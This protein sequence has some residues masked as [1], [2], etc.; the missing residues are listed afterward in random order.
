[1]DTLNARRIRRVIQEPYDPAAGT[2]AHL[3]VS[4]AVNN[5][6]FEHL[7]KYDQRALNKADLLVV[8]YLL[9]FAK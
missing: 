7:Q 9:I 2:E 4:I 3:F 8:E 5:S 6:D 1:M